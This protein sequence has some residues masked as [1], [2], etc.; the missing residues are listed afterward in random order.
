MS[1]EIALLA[2]QTIVTKTDLQG[3]IFYANDDF[4]FIS[5]FHRDELVGKQH[6]IVRHPDMPS[7]L[8]RDL[9]ETLR[10]GLPWNGVVKNRCKNGD[11]YWVNAYVAPIHDNGVIIGYASSRIKPTAAQVNL[12]ESL[13]ADM[14]S[15]KAR[16]TVKHG[17]L[18]PKNLF[19]RY[20]PFRMGIASQLKGMTVI[21]TTGIVGA[22]ALAFSIVDEVKVK[23][24][25]YSHIISG[26]DLVADILPPPAYL[27]ETWLTTLEMTKAD[28][29][30]LPRYI[31]YSKGLYNDYNARLEFWRHHLEDGDIKKVLLDESEPPAREF[32]AI[33]DN[34]LIPALMTNDREKAEAIVP[35]LRG[36]YERHR[37]AID[38]VVRLTNARN[39]QDESNTDI[40]LS[41]NLMVL[42]G[43]SLSLMALVIMVGTLVTK[44]ITAKLGGE[45]DYASDV[46]QQIAS[47]NLGLLV[48]SS[49]DDS[50]L[51]SISYMQSSLNKLLSKIKLDAQSVSDVAGRLANESEALQNMSSSQSA[52]AA[53]IARSSEQMMVNI[54]QVAENADQAKAM[55]MDSKRVC[56]RGAEIITDAVTSMRSIAETVHSTA[57]TVNDLGAHSDKIASVVKVIHSIADQTNLLALNA[58]IEAARAGEAG[59]GFAV[60]ADEVRNL[61]KRTALATEEITGI[62]E[63]IQNGMQNAT[64]AMETGVNQVNIGVERASEAGLAIKTI[65]DSSEYVVSS[66]SSISHAMRE[67]SQNSQNVTENIES[68]SSTASENSGAATKSAQAARE[69][70]NAALKLSLEIN[71]F[72]E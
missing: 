55:S 64:S 35:K 13:Y 46:A 71:R 49:G 38:D 11:Y 4:C 14:K 1:K 6:N 68:I 62:I 18:I 20:N 60:V 72:A 29:E 58:A 5:G 69:L 57:T 44:K 47:G 65:Q 37:K 23:G 19:L 15:G 36:I 25:I 10:K 45:P 12:S 52:F 33:L 59:R 61:A 17:K 63:Q 32:F 28:R 48:K 21:F 7:E 67:Q 56:V 51:A 39:A 34:E 70:E 24:S 22:S 16:Y 54:M 8:F 31:K 66:I 41:H 2:G 30:E 43:L 27:V 3:K 42:G 40:I 53:N 26:K 9:W 50:L